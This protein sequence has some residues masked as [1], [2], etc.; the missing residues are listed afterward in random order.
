[1]RTAILK[2]LIEADGYVSGQRLSQQLGVSRTA[3]WK[4]IKVLKA[5]GYQ[6]LS[7]QN[8]GYLLK[9]ETGTLIEEGIQAHLGRTTLFKQVRVY[10]TVD[11]TNNQAKRLALQRPV[12]AS[13]VI[14]HE[15]TAGKGRRGNTWHSENGKGIWMS[16]LLKPSIDPQVAPML[17]L[18]AALSVVEAIDIQ[19]GLEAQIKWPND[20]VIAGKK[21]CG[22]LT[23]MSS[24]KDYIE[25]VI[26][27]IGVNVNQIKFPKAIAASATSLKLLLDKEV[28]QP[29][30]FIKIVERFEARY[31]VFIQDKNLASMIEAYNAVCMNVD[32]PLKVIGKHQ[33][34]YGTGVSVTKEGVLQVLDKTGKIFEVHAGEV[35]IRGLYGYSE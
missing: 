1:M 24:E 12:E 27:G 8:K 3:I 9:E 28:H 13:L 20:V 18:V 25:H 15:Q 33:Q 22:I 35:S 7:V 34:Q 11:S 32:Q 5:E 19:T 30:L 29:D 6:I 16:M 23:E 17:T 21:V 31:K 4:N 10:K 26:V 14:A 2:V